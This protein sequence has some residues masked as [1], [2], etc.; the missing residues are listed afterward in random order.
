[1]QLTKLQQDMLNGEQGSGTQ[2]AMEIIV[3]LAKIYEADVLLPIKSCQ[4]SGVSY[5]NIGEAGLEFL[6]ELRAGGARSKVKATLNPCGIDLENW[7]S[8]GYSKEYHE[9]QRRVLD[10]YEGLGVE[11]TCTCTP[12]LLDNV[13]RY[14]DHVS[15]SESSAVSYVN[16]V[17]G[18]RTN[19]EGGPSALAAALTGFTGNYGLHLDEN[20]IPE[21]KVQINVPIKDY[22]DFGKLGLIMGS[23][24]GKKI[25]IFSGLVENYCSPENLRQLGAAMAASGA[26]ALYH[27][28]GITKEAMLNDN[29][30]KNDLEEIHVDNLAIICDLTGL[31]MQE[32]G[33]VSIDLVFYGCPHYSSDEI[34]SL[35]DDLRGKKLKTPLWIATSRSIRQELLAHEDILNDIDESVKIIADTC[36][37]VSPI[38]TL[39]IKSVVTNSA[40]AYFYLKNKSFLDVHYISSSECIDAAV[41]GLMKNTS[42]GNE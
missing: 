41:N 11:P 35:L 33:A 27:V 22:I 18:A 20:R 42:K 17:I 12:Y 26:I 25:P 34:L 24:L 4:V 21:V 23:K 19:R 40:K 31:E 13:P 38:D 14:G 16:S 39:N 2:I 3:T 1:M 8:L 28:E 5:G 9:N 32:S 29:W 6:E 30:S 10:A 36:I 15:W 37:V 7:E